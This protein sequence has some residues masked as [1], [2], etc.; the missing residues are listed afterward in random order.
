MLPVN[1]KR[2]MKLK[3]NAAQ[4]KGKI[5]KLNLKRVDFASLKTLF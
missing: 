4:I 1:L 2:F 3:E 5:G